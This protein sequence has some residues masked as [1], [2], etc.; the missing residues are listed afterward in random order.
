MKPY[1]GFV[2]T[3]PKTP[4]KYMNKLQNIQALRGVAVLSVVFFHLALIEKRYGG[5]NSVLPEFFNFGMFGV[6]LFF[7]ISGFVMVTVTRGKFQSLKHSLLFLYH[8]ISRIYPLYW[9]YTTVALIVFLV[10]PSWVN[11]SQ[12]NQV[13]I[14]ASYLLLPANLLPLVQVGWTLIHEMYFYL[15]FFVIMLFLP[16]RLLT[17]AMLVWG[18]VVVIFSSS[19]GNPYYRLILNPLTMEFLIGCLLAVHYHN[20]ASLKLNGKG[21]VAVA[22]IGMLAAILGYIYYESQTGL[23]PD[24]WSRLLYY[25]IPAT[26]IVFCITHAERNGVVLHNSLIQS[27]NASFSIYLSHLFTIN[28]VGRIWSLFAVEA[29]FDNIIVL[30]VE[31]VLVLFVGFISY[32]Y[33][34]TPLLKLSRRF[35]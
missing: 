35:A 19:T 28:V 12:G 5:A 23:A 16:E 25:G 26:I 11:S 34:E 13:N 21:L 7:V 10:Q 27:G 1:N 3:S 17:V 30:I 31:F 14:L 33:V 4:Y 20:A 24:G 6:D 18:V 8:R 9:V 15:V 2:I 29:V 22:S 32:W